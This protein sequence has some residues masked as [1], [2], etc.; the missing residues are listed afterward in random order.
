MH[1]HSNIGAQNDSIT[2]S[3][4]WFAAG[5]RKKASL[6]NHV[7]CTSHSQ[8][9]VMTLQGEV[10]THPQEQFCWFLCQSEEHG[11]LLRECFSLWPKSE[12]Y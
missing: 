11:F 6:L 2:Q 7:L 4:P 8:A 3:K 12:Y 9:Y 10:C 5:K 1:F